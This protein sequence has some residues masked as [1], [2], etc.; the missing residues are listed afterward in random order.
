MYSSYYWSLTSSYIYFSRVTSIIHQ[1]A[2][3]VF[4]VNHITNYALRNQEFACAFKMINECYCSSAGN[5]F[6]LH[7]N[8]QQMHRLKRKTNKK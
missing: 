7:N 3:I 2:R 4:Q 8:T 6:N 1:L 5:Q